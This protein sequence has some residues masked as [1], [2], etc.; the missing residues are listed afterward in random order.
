MQEIFFSK[1]KAGSLQGSAP[2][3]VVVPGPFFALEVRRDSAISWPRV[4]RCA[5]P[6]KMDLGCSSS[7]R[8]REHFAVCDFDAA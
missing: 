6:P 4:Q 5:F 3:V 2:Y 7:P 8:W 1:L